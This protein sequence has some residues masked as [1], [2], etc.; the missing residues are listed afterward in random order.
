MMSH[1]LRPATSPRLLSAVALLAAAAAV[2]VAPRAAM[3]QAAPHHDV[4]TAAARTEAGV[5]VAPATRPLP[6][7]AH[8]TVTVN[9]LTIFYREAGPS[10]APTVLLLHGFPTSSH[11]YRDLIPA[12]AD[13]YHVVAPDFPGFGQSSMPSREEFRYTFANLAD[14]TG[15][16]TEALGLDRYTL[17]VMDYGAPVGYRLALAHPERVEALVVQNGN[18]YD[19]GL[20]EFWAPLRRYWTSGSAADRDSLRGVLTLDATRWQY[21]HGVRDSTR[22]SPD[23]WILDQRYLDRPGN[24]EIQLDLFYDYRTN[25]PLYPAFQEYFR[26]HQPPTLI[27]WGRNDHIFPWQGAEPYKRDLRTIEYHLLDTGHFALE[28][29]GA[30]IAALMRGFLARHVGPTARRAAAGDGR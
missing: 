28:E 22:V 4:R 8:R 2:V 6:A 11:M 18:A 24:G 5:H 14:V 29:K 9:G 3:A 17:Y 21:L 26:R 15:R 16:F 30:E 1:A 27:V 19:E 7:V 23:G 12:L 20:R 10:D 25:V 13:R